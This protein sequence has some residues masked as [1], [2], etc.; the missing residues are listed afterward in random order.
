[1]PLL[2]ST[3]VM[4]QAQNREIINST[5]KVAVSFKI[6]MT[7]SVTR[8]YFTTQHQTCKTKTD[9]FWSPSSHV[10]RPTVSDHTT[11]QARRVWYWMFFG[12]QACFLKLCDRSTLSVSHWVSF[13]KTCGQ[14]FLLTFRK[15]PTLRVVRFSRRMGK[16]TSMKDVSEETGWNPNFPK[17]LKQRWAQL[18]AW[19]IRCAVG[20]AVSV[21]AI[22]LIS[23]W[24]PWKGMWLKFLSFSRKVELLD[25]YNREFGS[26]PDFHN[27]LKWRQGRL[28]ISIM[29]I[30]M[31]CRC[32]C[33][34]VRAVG[35][36]CA[37]HV[38]VVKALDFCSLNVAVPTAIHKLLM[39]LGM[40]SS[41][42]C[43]RA[44]EKP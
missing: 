3:V 10:L 21:A 37:F 20:P 25:P 19:V 23:Y 29:D 8:P 42:N 36:L 35:L 26:S 40:L 30:D 41:Q 5:L 18:L 6:I 38:S 28:L 34:L 7:T 27:T 11:D 9:F 24:H 12:T 33:V 31:M 22:G 2:I 4:L 16:C 1:M 13:K 39:A 14:K 17:T 44:P 15:G 43:P 32:T